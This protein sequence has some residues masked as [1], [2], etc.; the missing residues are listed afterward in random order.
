[1]PKNHA[2]AIITWWDHMQ[3]QPGG[4]EAF[5]QPHTV[6][7]MLFGCLRSLETDA[8]ASDLTTRARIE[9]IQHELEAW[10]RRRNRIFGG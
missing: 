8:L 6:S 4:L 5:E 2:L 3:L 10:M 1:M 9:T 7:T